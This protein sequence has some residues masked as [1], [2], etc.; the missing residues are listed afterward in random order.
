VTA[1][2]VGPDLAGPHLALRATGLLAEFN[3]AEVLEAADVHVAQ[4]LG[5]LTGED[6]P[7][8]LLAVALAVR[9]ARLGAVCVDLATVAA[10]PVETDAPLP[11]P[12]AQA[13]TS[14]VEQSALAAA[15]VL[16]LEGSLLYLDRHWREERQVCDDLIARLVR[17]APEVDEVLLATS[18]TRLFRAGWEEQREVSVSATRQW[19]TVLTG[20]PGTGKTA[21]VARLLVL[22]SEQYEAET[23]RSPRIALAAPTGKAATRLEES[24]AREAAELAPSD[25]TRLDGLEATTVHR[26]LGWR[27]DS[28]TR[29]RH[30]RENPLPYDVVVV[31]E[32][33]MV[34][35]SQMARLLEAVRPQCRLVLVGDPDQLSS[36]EAGAVLADLVRGFAGW[37][38]SPVL[39]L[40]E[41]H[42][43]QAT[44]GGADLD[45]LA[46]ALRVG[47]ADAALS[48]L[49]SGSPAV[50]LVDPDDV[51][52][53]AA[54]RR[55]LVDAAYA[56]NV[57]ADRGD[58]LTATALLDEHRLLCAHRRGPFGVSG[59]NRE[60]ERL[61]AERTGVTHYD[62]WYSGRPVLV[63]AND[64]G[65][66][67]SNGDLGVAV[68]EP[69]GRLRVAIRAGDGVR[70]LAPTRLSGVETVHAMTVHKSQGS[71]ARSV[72]VILPPEDSRLLTRELFYTAATRARQQ[73]VVVGT[74]AALRAAVAR[75]VQRASGLA[76]RLSSATE[77]SATRPPASAR[78]GR[79]TG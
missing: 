7:R 48:V 18:A 58:G 26:L 14:A 2:T 10:Q 49:R 69:D 59:W 42:R 79:T 1:A 77:Q 40:T 9:A 16:R 70:E 61:L 56:V 50:R 27:P 15:G 45:A 78:S 11:W 22:V 13:W 41:T 39:P 20:G 33:S 17:P 63:T 8:V 30:H 74:E 46:A 66:R 65:L 35:L 47:D 55:T 3:R 23:G 36:V 38:S 4:R 68:R 60:V 71:E 76:R 44:E 19:T 75:P 62:E 52:A 51:E 29:F 53:M 57:A 5:A 64:R 31:D 24:V 28:G 67:L 21:S 43:T 54:V 37:S 73:V 25:R 32:V 12:A 6:D 34:S 72:T